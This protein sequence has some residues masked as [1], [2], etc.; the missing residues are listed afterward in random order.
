MVGV[1]RL[2]LRCGWSGSG[3][4]IGL[5]RRAAFGVGVRG[6]SPQDAVPSTVWSACVGGLA[7]VFVCLFCFLLFQAHA[8]LWFIFPYPFFGG[9]HAVSGV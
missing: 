4:L 8:F 2:G 1:M 6:L 3:V 7:F 5:F 9:H